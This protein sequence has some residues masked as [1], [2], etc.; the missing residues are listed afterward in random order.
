[1]P[2][3][4]CRSLIGEG[5][6]AKRPVRRLRRDRLLAA[7]GDERVQL[8][9][10]PLD[11]PEV[12]LDELARGHLSA[13]DELRLLGRGQEG[14]LVHSL[15]SSISTAITGPPG[16]RSR[17][18]GYLRARRA[19]ASGSSTIRALPR[20]RTHQSFDQSSS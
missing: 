8:G 15:R 5:H 3:V 7:D 14:E 12:E 19:I 18:C 11:P 1:M 17:Y 2:A 4:S 9:I 13:A 16:G 10:E 6:A 20:S